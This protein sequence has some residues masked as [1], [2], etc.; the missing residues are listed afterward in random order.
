MVRNVNIVRNTRSEAVLKT[1]K[2]IYCAYRVQFC[3]QLVE[4]RRPYFLRR[5]AHLPLV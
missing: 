3:V 4:K 1:V 5:A 2:L